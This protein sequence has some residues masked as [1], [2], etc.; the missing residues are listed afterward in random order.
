M[1]NPNLGC[2]RA[3]DFR[4]LAL[5]H[6]AERPREFAAPAGFADVSELL[7]AGVF[8]LVAAGEVVYVGR[9]NGP[10]LSRIA[11]MKSTDRPRC[12]PAIAFDQIL[13]R[14]VHPDRLN[15]LY[16]DLKAKYSRPGPI[17]IERRI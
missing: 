8:L 10:M 2:G 16:Y 3:A 9:A 1:L 4:D 6:R 15:S 7:A 13:I 5:D 17:L 11:A 14:P 12:I